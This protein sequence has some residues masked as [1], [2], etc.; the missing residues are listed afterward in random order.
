M[1]KIYPSIFFKLMGK[2][3]KVLMIWQFTMSSSSKYLNLITYRGRCS[4]CDR[5]KPSTDE[6]MKDKQNVCNCCNFC[7]NH[8]DKCTCCVH[9]KDPL[10]ECK[11][12]KRALDLYKTECMCLICNQIV[13]GVLHKEGEHCPETCFYCKVETRYCK[14]CKK[15]RGTPCI[16]CTDCKELKIFCK[17]WGARIL[18]HFMRRGIY[19]HKKNAQLC[20]LRNSTLPNTARLLLP[21]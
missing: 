8:E 13:E 11:C 17:C 15:C 9:C 2:F 4:I 7:G 21:H 18:S 10:N 19:A 1:G 12:R 3:Y 20:A 6:E 14:C 16:C 5:I